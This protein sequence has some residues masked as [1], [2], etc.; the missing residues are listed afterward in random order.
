[1]RPLRHL[2]TIAS[3]I[4]TVAPLWL[5]RAYPTWNASVRSP[6]SKYASGSRRISPPQTSSM[7]RYHLRSSS[8]PWKTGPSTA[9]NAEWSSMLGSKYAMNASMSPALNASRR[10][11]LSST[12]RPDIRSVRPVPR[13]RREAEVGER[14]LAVEVDDVLG[15]LA[16]VEVE[17][18]RS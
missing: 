8:W 13:L 7:P 18:Q 2:A 14:V 15:H 6:R 16:V 4:E 5:P 9:A 11:R 12:L 10:R 3:G 17:E 1:M